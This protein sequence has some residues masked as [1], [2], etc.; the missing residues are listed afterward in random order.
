MN[1]EPNKQTN[2]EPNKQTKK[3]TILPIKNIRNGDYPA[4]GI[5]K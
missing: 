3:Q 1:T 5:A 4:M 2:T